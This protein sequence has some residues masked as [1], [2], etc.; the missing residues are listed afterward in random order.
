MNFNV[1]LTQA[2]HCLKVSSGL[3]LVQGGGTSVSMGKPCSD[4]KENQPSFGFEMCTC[5]ATISLT[6][7]SAPSDRIATLL[8]SAVGFS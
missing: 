8:D 2:R 6:T 3:L 5:P 4:T 7:T 1:A